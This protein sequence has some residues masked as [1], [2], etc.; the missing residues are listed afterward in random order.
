[1]GYKPEVRRGETYYC[2]Q[3]AMVGTRFP[4]KVCGTAAEIDRVT[5]GSRETTDKLQRE[6]IG[7]PGK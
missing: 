7:P 4:S 5:V 6:Q 1:M 3:E 2:R